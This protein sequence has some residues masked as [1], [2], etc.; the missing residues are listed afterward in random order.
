[1]GGLTAEQREVIERMVMGQETLSDWA[2]G[3][4]YHL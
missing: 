3:R 4:G 1:M 2:L